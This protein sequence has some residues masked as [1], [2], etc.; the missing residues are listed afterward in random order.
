MQQILNAVSL[1]LAVPQCGV[2]NGAVTGVMPSN[3]RNAWLALAFAWAV[4]RQSNVEFPVKA[5]E[6]VDSYTTGKSA[7][8]LIALAE[9]T[10]GNYQ[11]DRPTVRQE[12]INQRASFIAQFLAHAEV[13]GF[14]HDSVAAVVEQM[15]IKM[16][17][18]KPDFTPFDPSVF[19]WGGDV[20]APA[21]DFSFDA[22]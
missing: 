9:A 18:A 22:V 2:F 21:D 7:K 16:L 17:A 10:M 15:N 8:F 20:P 12:R 4:A 19:G 14:R 11:K 6:P 13:S 1:L 3:R 5:G